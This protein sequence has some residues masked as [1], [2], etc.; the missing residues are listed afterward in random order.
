MNKIHDIGG[1]AG[2]GPIDRSEI[3]APFEHEWEARV[4]VMN[5]LLIKR[6]VYNIDEFRNAVERL[7][8][9]DYF[10]SSYYERWLLAIETLLK[11]KGVLA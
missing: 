11:E 10:D 1:Q 4:F 5:R 7:S 6:G 8:P 2:F 9:H 3:D